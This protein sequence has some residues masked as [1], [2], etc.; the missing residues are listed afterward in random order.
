MKSE[1]TT[2]SSP[3]SRTLTLLDLPKALLAVGRERRADAE[4]WGRESWLR[5]S[6]REHLEHIKLHVLAYEA[7]GDDDGEP[8]LAH[9][10]LRI[11]MM[12]ECDEGASAP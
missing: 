3:P 1:K 9:A 8:H 2:R 11:L 10:A 6:H 4:K 12:L 7:R 5:I